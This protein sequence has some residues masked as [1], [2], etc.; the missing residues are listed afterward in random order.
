MVQ[1]TVIPLLGFIL[2]TAA[3]AQQPPS[4]RSNDGQNKYLG[5]LSSNRYDPDSVSNPYGRYGSPFSPDSVNNPYGIY[6]S[7]Y[8]SFSANNPY[9]TQAPK[10]VT[11][12]GQYLGKYSAN[13]YDSDSSSNLYGQYGSRYSPTS[14]NNPYSTYGS[15]YS[16]SSV[17]NP[18][19]SHT[20]GS[21]S[22]PSLSALPALPKWR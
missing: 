4:L 10:I 21:V 20:H 1:R 6:G 18:F 8:S 13:P 19:A 11:G 14:I 9:T 7:R 3:V 17:M 2:A 15:R 22:V 5:T 16:P 12:S